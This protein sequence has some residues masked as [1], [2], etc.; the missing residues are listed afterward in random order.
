MTYFLPGDYVARSNATHFL[1]NGS[2]LVY[3]PQVYELA[4]F[5]A[6]RC[7][8]KRIIDIGCGSGA[9]LSP[10]AGEFEIFGVDCDATIPLFRNTVPAAKWLECDLNTAVPD[11]PEGLLADAVVI[12]ADVIEHLSSPDHLARYL[13]YIS[14]IAPFVFIS[15]PDR[16]RV[17]GWLDRGP[18]TNPCHV[19]E[20]NSCEFLRFLRNSGFSDHVLY[21]HTVNTDHHLSNTT[22]LAI[23]GSHA[24]LRSTALPKKVAAIIH[25]FNEVDILSEVVRHLVGQGI[26]VYLFDNWSMDGTW[27]LAQQLERE[28]ILACLDRYPEKPVDEY[29]WAKLLKHTEDVASTIDADW[30]IHQDAD[31]LRYCPWPNTTLAEGISWID[32]LGYS[33]I[34]FTVIDFRFLTNSKVEAGPYESSLNHFQFGRRDGHFVQIKAWKSRQKVAL[35]D[36]GGHEAVFEDRRIFPLKFLT[37]HY[38]LRSV[39]QA[40]K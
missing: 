18:P 28:G 21:G 20:W 9:K 27:E 29:Q 1:D 30:V 13:A 37:K 4:L 40:Q 17:R 8:A 32:S 5:V 31:E 7:G 39:R 16:D 12:C 34:D 38:P 26:Q 35:V 24:H 11:I 19:M 10:F 25:C 22:L 33:A 3:Q 2:Q 6:R 23:S 15:T 14:D 36:S